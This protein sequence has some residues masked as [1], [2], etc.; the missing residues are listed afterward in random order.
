MK[1]STHKKGKSSKSKKRRKS[2]KKLKGEKNK[3]GLMLKWVVNQGNEGEFEPTEEMK[4]KEEDVQGEEIK[5]E[6]APRTED[7]KSKKKEKKGFV[8]KRNKRVKDMKMRKDIII[9]L[10]KEEWGYQLEDILIAN[11]TVLDI[12]F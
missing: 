5:E 4:I 1:N 9:V 11:Q 8:Q 10:K 7:T 6:E 12:E 3:Q 2:T